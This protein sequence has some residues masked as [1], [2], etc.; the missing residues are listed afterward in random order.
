MSF[1]SER[2]PFKV[3]LVALVLGGLVAGGVVLLSTLSFGTTTYTAVLEHT[4]GLRAGEDVQVHGVSVG[5]V[6]SVELGEDDVEVRFTVDSAIQLGEATTAEVKVATLLGNHYLEVDPQ[7]AGSLAHATIPLEQT[8][9][10]YNLQDVLE[11]GTSSLD[12]LDPDL[13]ARALTATSDAL[14][15]SGEEVGPA[16][17]G[18]AQL[19]DVISA[20]S[21]QTGRLLRAA[22]G[23]SD[24]L[25]AGSQDL[26][27]LMRSANL[28]IEEVVNR[29]EAI[30][31][32]LVET[33]G[34]ADALD[35][36]VAQTRGDL[37]PALR[38]LNTAL[39]SLR[40]Q[41]R[42]LQDVLVQMAPAVRYVANATGNGP[43]LDLFLNS[44]ALPADDANCALRNCR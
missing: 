36:I 34:L 15:A 4:A 8:A 43:Y 35:Q 23:V 21:T 44:P 19:S 13:L 25:N 5:E 41:D 22:R 32:L 24:Q 37:D 28:V 3:G 31:Q 33:R 42:Q 20:R 17:Q 14:G 29:R 16:L 38:D 9:V 40:T 2:D 30:H 6:R 12:Q 18:I 7:G 27:A 26:F 1:L 11:Q 10:P 39:A